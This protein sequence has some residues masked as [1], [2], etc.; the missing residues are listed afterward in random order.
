MHELSL[1]DYTFE[2]ERSNQ[3]HLSI[4]SG[5]NGFSFCIFDNLQQKHIVFRR[6]V[7]DTNQLIEN[8]LTQLDE[9][10][11]NDDL[12]KLHF[13]S[14]AFLYLTQKSTLIPEIYFNKNELKSYF[15]FNQSID[16]LDE[17]H[18]NYLPS[19]NAYNVFALH[20]YIISAV[21]NQVKGIRFYHQALPFIEKVL[22][23]NAGFNKKVLTIS[24]NYNF[25]D[26]TVTSGNKLL[27][28]NTFQ[29]AGKEDL[30]YFILFIC[31]Q[32]NMNPDDTD[33][34]L[35]GELA[36]MMLYYDAIREYIPGVKHISNSGLNLASSLNRIKE[37]KYLTLF[38]LSY[39]A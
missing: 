25:F 31:K 30:I 14:A 27:L 2:K 36:D 21:S 29:Y 7:F 18:F 20:S 28:Y 4:Q 12:L 3:Y 22:Q 33:L 17:L 24:L 35:S 38:N 8:Y 9:I 13:A 34:F 32:F 26:L 19:V 16:M 10:F 37:Y 23:L 15:E 11:K 5:L 39:C 6:Y 1:V